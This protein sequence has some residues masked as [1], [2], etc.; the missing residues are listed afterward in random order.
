MMPNPPPQQGGGSGAVGGGMMPP[1]QGE[2]HTLPAEVFHHPDFEAIR[3]SC[4]A[5]F[6]TYCENDNNGGNRQHGHHGW[7]RHHHH[8]RN[9][10]GGPHRGGFRCIHRMRENWAQIQDGCKATLTAQLP[11]IQDAVT[12]CA[13]SRGRWEVMECLQNVDNTLLSSRCSAFLAWKDQMDNQYDNDNN[14]NNSEQPPSFADDVEEDGEELYE[15]HGP[16]SRKARRHFFFMI[17]CVALVAAMIGSCCTLCCMRRRC[18]RYNNG[19]AASGG[20]GCCRNAA[21]AA[22]TRPCCTGSVIPLQQMPASRGS[23]YAVFQDEVV[24]GSPC[25]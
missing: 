17:F 14:N 22:C 2:V 3:Q 23:G 21:P 20:G 5:D 12:H 8:G 16:F 11:C 19:G 13:A 10:H 4:A 25:V 24:R 6:A 9:H 18:R 7:S 1:S 15:G